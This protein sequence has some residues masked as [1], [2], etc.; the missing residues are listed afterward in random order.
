MANH[1]RREEKITKDVVVEYCEW[2]LNMRLIKFLSNPP[3][4]GMS[5]DY[6]LCF[7]GEEVVLEVITSGLSESEKALMRSGA[8]Y[9]EGLVSEWI[10]PGQTINL[11]IDWL[12]KKFND[13]FFKDINEALKSRFQNRINTQMESIVCRKN[14]RLEAFSTD[15]YKDS[16]E[17][18]PL[19]LMY[20]AALNSS[21]P[22]LEGNLSLNAQS[23]LLECITSKEL[24]YKKMSHR[25]WLGIYNEHPL[26]DIS[27]YREAYD[28]LKQNNQLSNSFENIFIIIEDRAYPLGGFNLGKGGWLFISNKPW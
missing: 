26:L 4:E 17:Y 10:L 11:T 7:H 9:L 19:R 5:P 1:E 15:F 23:V 28:L 16:P 22:A 8:L 3:V 13:A 25:K 20:G 21:N 27:D 14:K 24:K 2:N 18:S 12:I 6:L